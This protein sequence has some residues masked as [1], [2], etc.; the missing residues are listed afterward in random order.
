MRRVREA[1][2]RGM[3]GGITGFCAQEETRERIREGVRRNDTA[4]CASAA[5]DPETTSG[6]RWLCT[7]FVH[8]ECTFRRRWTN[9]WTASKG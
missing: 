1:Q 6:M 3:K 7:A 5:I 4:D 8:F 2:N 9:T